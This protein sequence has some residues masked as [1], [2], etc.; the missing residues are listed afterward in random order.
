[1]GLLIVAYMEVGSDL[2]IPPLGGYV[3]VVQSIARFSAMYFFKGEISLYY[4]EFAKLNWCSI[5]ILV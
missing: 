1:M 2:A 5:S 3:S 4:R